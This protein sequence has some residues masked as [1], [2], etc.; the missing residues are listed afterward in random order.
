M[1]AARPL[2]PSDPV[3]LGPY[4]LEGRLGEGGQSVVFLGR[5]EDG[6]E[7]AIKLLRAALSQNPEWR[8]RFERELRLIGRVA[9]FCTAQ[10]ID[11]TSPASFRTS[12]ASTCRARR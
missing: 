9:G 4:D 3:R 11:T 12:S 5:G 7:V 10:V 2:L 8:A 1:T 6:R